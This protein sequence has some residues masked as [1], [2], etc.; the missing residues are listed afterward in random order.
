[1]FSYAELCLTLWNMIIGGVCSIHYIFLRRGVGIIIAGVDQPFSRS[2]PFCCVVFFWTSF[3]LGTGSSCLQGKEPPVFH[4][5]HHFVGQVQPRQ[6]MATSAKWCTLVFSGLLALSSIDAWEIRC[7]LN[8]PKISSIPDTRPD[9]N[10][11]TVQVHTV[12]ATTLL[13]HELITSLNQHLY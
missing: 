8:R 6:G 13:G 9:T 1:M 11:S 10:Y 3:W 2:S 5:W 7:I 12:Y 4:I